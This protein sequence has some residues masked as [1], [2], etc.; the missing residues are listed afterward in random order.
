M[1]RDLPGRRKL[2]PAMAVAKTN[3]FIV[4]ANRKRELTIHV[5][6]SGSLELR[7]SF[8]TPISA[9]VFLSSLQS[10]A[11]HKMW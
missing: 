1:G 3:W 2:R 8:C 6:D 11:R 4:C 10:E 5:G 9:S 7:A